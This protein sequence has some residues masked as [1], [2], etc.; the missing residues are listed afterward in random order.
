MSTSRSTTRSRAWFPPRRSATGSCITRSAPSSQPIFERGFIANSFANREGKGTHRAIE[1]YERYR[2]RHRHVLRCD[3]YRYFP[4]HRPRD[5]EGRIPPPHRLRARRCALMDAIVDG[6][7]AQERVDLYFPGDDLLAP[8]ARRR[9]LPIGNLTS[10]FFANLYLDRLDHFVTEV[11]RAP[12]VRYVDDFALFHDDPEVL[13]GWR[14][15]LGALSARA[16]AAS[17]IRARPRFW[18][19]RSRRIPRLRAGATWAPPPAGGQRPPVSQPPARYARPL[20]GG[21]CRPEAVET[22]VDGVDRPRASM[23]TL[24]ACAMR[25]SRG[26]W[27]DPAARVA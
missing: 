16:A 1:T 4:R 23:P 14:D 9:G 21:N 19:P 2:D 25:S 5:P 6:S 13:A 27:F 22:H 26:G 7:N 3:I 17:C 18:R 24:G 10:Q 15:R 12:Y 8:L 11:L 20:A